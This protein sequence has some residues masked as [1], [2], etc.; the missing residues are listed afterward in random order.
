MARRSHGT[1]RV[2]FPVWAIS[3]D[4]IVLNIDF[5]FLDMS[6]LL[7]NSYTGPLALAV[8]DMCNVF[9]SITDMSLTLLVYTWRATLPP[10]YGRPF[11][12]VNHT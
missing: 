7:S 3:F 6:K 12:V 1:V 4:K 2:R 5:K 10:V 8:M 11:H 9:G